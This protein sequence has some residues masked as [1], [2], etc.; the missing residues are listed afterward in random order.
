[1]TNQFPAGLKMNVIGLTTPT[2]TGYSWI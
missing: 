2:I 1:V